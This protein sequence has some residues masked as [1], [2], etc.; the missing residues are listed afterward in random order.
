MKKIN[1]L[2]EKAE[3]LGWKCTKGRTKYS[4]GTESSYI[5][6]AQHSP[7]GEDFSFTAYGENAYE[8]AM[9]VFEYYQDFDLSEHVMLNLGANGAPDAYDLAVDAK[10]IEGMLEA[11]STKL[12]CEFTR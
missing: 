9:S 6:F 3:E 2:I 10:A 1:L 12:I 8:I 5:E 7:A 4:D 11:L